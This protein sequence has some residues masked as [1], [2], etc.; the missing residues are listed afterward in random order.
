MSSAF[1]EALRWANTPDNLTAFDLKTLAL[2]AA[3]IFVVFIVWYYYINYTPPE[4]ESDDDG[5]IIVEI[6]NQDNAVPPS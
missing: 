4:E 3:A 2:T 6:D 1:E 5:E